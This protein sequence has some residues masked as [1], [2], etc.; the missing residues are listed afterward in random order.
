M[1]RNEEGAIRWDDAVAEE[2]KVE[3]EDAST[4][5][6]GIFTYALN[7]ARA[8][9]TYKMHS[10]MIVLGLLRNEQC[11]A[12]V[13]LSKECGLDDLYGAWHEVLWTLNAANGL[14]PV[15]YKAEISYTDLALRIVCSSTNFAHWGGRDKVHSEDILMSLAAGNVLQDLFPDLDL[16]FDHIRR[17]AAKHGC[18]YELPEDSE[19]DKEVVEAQDILSPA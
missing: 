2:R 7:M 14:D 10:W 6:A 19:E 8:S 17:S 9:E 18:K 11:K 1:P 3:N 16:S 15:A 13:I 5:A 12:S 4:N